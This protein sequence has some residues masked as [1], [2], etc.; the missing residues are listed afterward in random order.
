MLSPGV[1][2]PTIKGLL[3]ESIDVLEEVLRNAKEG[4]NDA[5][6][7]EA[8]FLQVKCI[9]SSSDLLYRLRLLPWNCVKKKKL[10]IY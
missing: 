10:K 2:T 1:N 3:E 5:D 6:C 9:L 7:K 8:I 4:R